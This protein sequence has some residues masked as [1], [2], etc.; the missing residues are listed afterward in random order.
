MGGTHTTESKL[1]GIDIQTSLLGTPI[2]LGWGR[3]KISCNLIDYVGFK[4][5]PKTTKTGGKGGSTSTT[6]TYTAS[7]ILLL[8]EGSIQGV[9]TV[10]RDSSVLTLAA[11]GLSL[12]TGGLT[13]SVWG[14][15]TSLFPSHAVEYSSLAYV[16]AQDYGLGNSASL[17]NHAFEVD[18]AVQ[19]AGL[20]DADPK[21]IVTD[22][23]TNVSYGVT[24]WKSGLIGSWTDWSLYCRA[25]NLLLSPTL[26]SNA[27]GADFLARIAE[28]TNSEFFCSEGLLKCKPYGD[29][30]VTGNSVT[31]TPDLTPVYDLDEDDFIGDVTLEIVDQSDAYNYVTVE[32]LDRTNQY[33]PAPMPAQDLDNIVTYGLRKRDAKTMH[34]V[35]IA[36][37]A[38]ILAQIE[39]QKTLYIREKYTFTLP[40]D[41][42]LLESM[43][44]V[45][46]TTTVDGMK[47]NRQLVLIKEISEDETGNLTFVASIVPGLTASAAAY[48]AHTSAGYQPAVDV[49]PGNIA[50]PKLFNAPTSLATH[51]REV[52]C[53]VAGGANWGGAFVWISADNVTYAQIGTIRGP[54][55]YGTLAAA[56]ANTA[57]PDTTNTLAVNLATSLGALGTATHAEADAGASM[58]LVGAELLAY[59]DQALT[60][61]YNYNLTYLRR[62]LRGTVPA[63]HAIGASFVRLDDAI[64]KFAY[65][66]ANTGGTIYLKFQSF[67]LYGRA[68]Q[69]LSGV[70]AYTLGLSPAISLPDTPASIALI[71]GGA[72]WSGAAINLMCATSARADSYQF[73]F[74]KADGTTFIRSIVSSTP[75]ASYTS[76]LAAT[77]GAQRGYKIKAKA[78]NAAGSSGYT[79]LLD[80]TNAAPAVVASPAATGG[81][82]V[83]TVS[84]SALTDADLG[85]Y[86]VFYS[87]TTGFNP[88]TT[89]AVV[90]SGAPSISIFGLPAAT[91]YCKI[92]AY[93]PWTSNPALLN[94][95]S[96]LS[97][98]ITT[99]GGSSPSGGGAAAGGYT[100]I[101]KGTQ[102]P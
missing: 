93:D 100:S 13:Q 18:F 5:I 59:A 16:Q 40:E 23:L 96:E 10:Y 91:F 84:C 70:M 94:L 4:A 62:G 74:Y 90:V 3:A 34:D 58:C 2:T 67:N 32:F 63:L 48:A 79:S 89:G 97:F 39:L 73:D 99:G 24:G 57:D 55:R 66:P 43:D 87:T 14:Y 85:G 86:V 75:Q 68:V 12:A 9:R 33:E 8:C 19:M 7:P 76:S 30:A 101:P 6:Y 54:A 102:I 80:I 78:I 61:A 60:S 56:L 20:A 95:S 35:K 83:G 29:T 65:D 77:D 27:T 15:L 47:L 38:Q 81:A 64:F 45:T 17:S 46:L 21:D 42:A 26:D 72:T 11:A 98:V 31:W 37:T 50:T 25:S 53:A 22:F 41:F 36:A 52:W 69:D 88:A 44:Y 49:D 28:Q 51:T 71:G 1:A 82:T 92:A